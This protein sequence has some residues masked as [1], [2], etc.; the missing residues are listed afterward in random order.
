MLVELVATGLAAK[1][2]EQKLKAEVTEGQ[3]EERLAYKI[4]HGQ[5]HI[6]QNLH[7][8]LL[9]IQ[10]RDGCV[11]GSDGLSS[12]DEPVDHAAVLIETPHLEGLVQRLIDSHAFTDSHHCALLVRQVHFDSANYPGWL[13]PTS[14]RASWWFHVACGGGGGGGVTQDRLR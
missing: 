9:A 11:P 7:D 14:R 2:M 8:Q 12:F 4:V 1:S 10:R 3:A 5:W 13:S 6:L